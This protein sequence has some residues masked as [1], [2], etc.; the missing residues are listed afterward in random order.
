MNDEI[1][2]RLERIESH[3]A[4]LERHHEQLNQVVV[5][6]GRLLKKLSIQNQRMA[7]TI[8]ATEIDRIRA[9]NPKPPHH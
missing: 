3:L 2:K 1:A 4:H 9:S 7:D 5:E 8:E 6:Q